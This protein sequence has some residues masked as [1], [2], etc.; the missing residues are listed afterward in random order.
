MWNIPCD[1]YDGPINSITSATNFDFGGET[2]QIL[3]TPGHSPASI[4]FYFP[5][6]GFVIAGDV[7]FKES[8]GR[9]DLPGA[10][11]DTLVKSILEKLYTLPDETIVYS[12]HGIPTTIGH[13]KRHNPFVKA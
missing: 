10:N 12:G 9:T 6:S 8:V 11:P 5:E 13:E 4:S 2:A 1:N 7:L 3:E